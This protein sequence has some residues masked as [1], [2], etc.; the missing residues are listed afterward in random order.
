MKS[1]AALAVVGMS[2]ALAACNRPDTNRTTSVPSGVNNATAVTAP[3]VTPS[4]SPA[5]AARGPIPPNANAEAP[6]TN[7][8]LAFQN[9][10]TGTGEKP[11]PSKS[12]APQDQDAHVKAQEAAA[13]APNTAA[14]DVA[15][16]AALSSDKATTGLAGTARDTAANGPQ[17]GMSKSEESNQ[18]PKAGQAN[19]HSSPALK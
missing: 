4:A 3:I 1:S 8:S 6:G 19:N 18:M 15:K 5:P 16:D 9:A 14:A 11:P 17:Q 2:L 12:G 10:T 7:A 13:E